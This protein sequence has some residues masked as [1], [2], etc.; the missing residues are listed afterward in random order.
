MFLDIET[1]TITE[2]MTDSRTE[3][4]SFS[5]IF[6]QVDGS[7]VT[8][9]KIVDSS[10]AADVRA[11]LISNKFNYRRSST[12]WIARAIACHNRMSNRLALRN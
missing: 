2:K 1:I 9:I 10:S 8:R 7:K 12:F 6:I 5:T 11:Q 4:E 3:A